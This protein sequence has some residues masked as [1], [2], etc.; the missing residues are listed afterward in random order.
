MKSYTLR[1]DT[2][3]HTE[4]QFMYSF[5]FIESATNA[6]TWQHG[7]ADAALA[8][9]VAVQVRRGGEEGEN[10]VQVLCRGCVVAC[11]AVACC[12]G[13][14]SR[15]LWRRNQ[16]YILIST[17]IRCSFLL[18]SSSSAVVRRART[19]HRIHPLPPLLLARQ[20]PMARAA[21]VPDD[22]GALE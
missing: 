9:D 18:P 16:P 13:I 6:T 10:I 8:A 14:L 4:L 2:V 3:T 7:M 19:V 12:S 1:P 21:A 17:H 11:S 20:Y 15:V 5:R 22:G